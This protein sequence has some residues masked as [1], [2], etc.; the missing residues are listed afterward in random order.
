MRAGRMALVQDPQ[1]AA[2]G[3][4][5]PG[6]HIGAHLVNDAGAFSL[7]QLNTP[8]P[9]AASAFYRAVLGWQVDQVASDPPYWGIQVEG[10]VNGGMMLM[11]AA[12]APA[13]WLVYF[14]THDI[15]ASALHIAELGGGILVPVTVVGEDQ[16]ILVAH[17][18]QGAHFALYEGRIDP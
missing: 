11:P 18:P 2:L 8:D 10:R 9:D 17:D 16:R 15:D 4:W 1:G 6:E 14:T 7:N 13:H 5:Q 12:A 3:L